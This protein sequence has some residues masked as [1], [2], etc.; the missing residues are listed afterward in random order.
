MPFLDQL[1]RTAPHNYSLCGWGLGLVSNELRGAV[2]SNWSHFPSWHFHKYMYCT[3]THKWMCV[4]MH[5]ESFLL[6]VVIK[7]CSSSFSKTTCTKESANHH[8]KKFIVQSISRPMIHPPSK[9]TCDQMQSHKV[10]QVG[11]LTLSGTLFATPF[12]TQQTH[13]T[14]LDMTHSQPRPRVDTWRA[15]SRYKWWHVHTKRWT[16]SWMDPEWIL[17]VEEVVGLVS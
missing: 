6:V 17:I 7:L 2:L 12:A 4:Y 3:Y 15:T 8:R 11:K 5:L 9:H 16:R 10:Y 13:E 14:T 1:E